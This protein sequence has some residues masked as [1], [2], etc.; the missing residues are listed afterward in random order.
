M[1]PK[2][3][4]LQRRLSESGPA[5]FGPYLLYCV[6][7]S[8]VCSLLPTGSSTTANTQGLSVSIHKPFI[9]RGKYDA[10][11]YCRTTNCPVNR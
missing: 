1:N 9:A 8:L 10:Q 6:A 7:L 11:T 4:V 2:S 5:L 3:N